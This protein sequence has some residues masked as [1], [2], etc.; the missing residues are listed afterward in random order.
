MCLITFAWDV[1]PK[2]KLIL[3]ANRDEFYKRPSAT[4]GFWHDDPNI[5]G[6]KDLQAG[7]SW[8]TVSKQGK[9]AAVTNFRDPKNIRPDAASRGKLPTNFL[10]TIQSAEE[11]L[12]SIH[13]KAGRFNGFN[14]LV[15]NFHELF[16]YSNYERKLNPISRGV[17]GLSN[18]LL[19]T[20]WPKVELAK[21]KLDKLIREDFNHDD[22]IAMM[23]DEAIADDEVLPDTGIP[24]DMERSLSS[25][26]I[27]MPE[28]GTCCSTAITVDRDGKV[29]F[30]EKSYP[31]GNRKD[32]TVRFSFEVKS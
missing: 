6:G 32:Q 25:M 15:G 18:A 3:A 4:A 19:N 28:Y 20:P 14:L 27:R 7:G 26:C 29:E 22:L 9:F 30:T 1:H 5:L 16:H 23:A 21:E 31:V 24:K 17:H 8:M 11:Y 13:E 2:Y 12:N 10:Q